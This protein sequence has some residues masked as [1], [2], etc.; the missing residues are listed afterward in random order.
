MNLAKKKCVPCEAGALPLT[1][2]EAEKYMQQVKGWHLSG[3]AKHISKEFKF[4]NF[5]E[6]MTF[7]NNIANVAEQEGHHPDLS[8]SW[9]RVA[10]ELSTHAI[11]GL[12]END[13]ILAAKIDQI[14]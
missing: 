11:K 3:D 8:I 14:A 7:A 1:K 6:A 10:I 2:E 9:G 13:F 12:S 5:L 4:K